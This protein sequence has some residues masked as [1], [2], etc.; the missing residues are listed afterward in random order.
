[1]VDFAIV[2]DAMIIFAVEAIGAPRFCA[3]GRS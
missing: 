1:M 3:S 2:A